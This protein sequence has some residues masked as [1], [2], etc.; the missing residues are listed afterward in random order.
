MKS[1]HAEAFVDE[2]KF[3]ARERNYHRFEKDKPIK[4][5]RNFEDVSSE[6]AIFENS[7]KITKSE[8]RLKTGR[9]SYE[10]AQF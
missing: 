3:V 9:L 6:S 10:N 7:F 5:Q 2:E 4:D 8:Q 1:L